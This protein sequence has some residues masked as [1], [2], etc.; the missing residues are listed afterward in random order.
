MLPMNKTW[1]PLEK[2]PSKMEMSNLTSKCLKK[3]QMM[4]MDRVK[5]RRQLLKDN[6]KIRL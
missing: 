2:W 4:R 6:R 3:L 5:D 1:R